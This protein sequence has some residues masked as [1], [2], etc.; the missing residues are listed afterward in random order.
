MSAATIDGRLRT[1]IMGAYPMG[2]GNFQ[3]SMYGG[4]VLYLLPYEKVKIEGIDYYDTQYQHASV[5][6]NGSQT[7]TR[8]V[9]TGMEVIDGQKGI[10]LPQG[11]YPV[12]QLGPI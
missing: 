7:S 12:W 1:V 11:P 5:F 9:V 4:R 3:G 10:S 6:N 2:T 8:G